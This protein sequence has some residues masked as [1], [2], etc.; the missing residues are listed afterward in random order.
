VGTFINGVLNMEQNINVPYPIKHNFQTIDDLF[1]YVKNVDILRL[2]GV[3]VFAPN[4]I[5][6]K[7]FNE[8]YSDLYKVRGN[9]PSIKFRYLQV[10]MDKRYN[11]LLHY[12]YPN[13]TSVFEDYEN[14]IYGISKSIHKAYFDRFIKNLYIKVPPEE[15]NIIKI[16]HN[17]H[18][19]DRTNNKINLNKVIDILNQQQPTNI[20]KMIRRFYLEQKKPEDNSKPPV[21]Y[22]KK[23]KPLMKREKSGESK[24][25][26]VETEA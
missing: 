7:I 24:T 12:L 9:E 11:K 14:I 6:Y 3:I 2:Q 19:E 15:F 16:C 20:N 17:W 5:Q 23:H 18:I 25:E 21:V 4:N 26:V 8:E 1:E 13:F 10:R 22:Q